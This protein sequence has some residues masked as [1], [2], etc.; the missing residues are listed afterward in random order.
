VWC[1]I[2]VYGSAYA[3]H[4]LDFISVLH[5]I[6][7]LDDYP[8]LVGGDF[9]LVRNASEKS[10]GNV[11]R[12]WSFLFN[13]WINK[14][15][16]INFKICNKSFTWANNQDTLIMAAIDRILA[17]TNWECHFP[18]T[19]VKALPRVGSD[20]TPLLLYTGENSPPLERMFRFEKWW[21]SFFLECSLPA[22]CCH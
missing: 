18:L 6:M 7:D 9:N 16:L 14:H 2:I 17:C 15:G 3:E 13:D 1:L 22:Q 12:H 5:D 10:N 21:I 20:H 4:K 8:T 19:T 11:N